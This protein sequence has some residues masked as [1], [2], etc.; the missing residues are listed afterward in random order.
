M[1]KTAPEN[2]LMIDEVLK[3]CAYAFIFCKIL[4]YYGWT[5]LVSLFLISQILKGVLDLDI[6]LWKK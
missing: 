4:M 6:E 5:I 3:V 2:S 1:V